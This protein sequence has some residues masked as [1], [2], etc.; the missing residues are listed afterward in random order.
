ME[1]KAGIDGQPC[2]APGH[3]RHLQ[4]RPT[5]SKSGKSDKIINN[6]DAREEQQWTIIM[7]GCRKVIICQGGKGGYLCGAVSC[8]RKQNILVLG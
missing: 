1:E 6:Q 3:L 5:D 2:F 4:W 8:R 7:D